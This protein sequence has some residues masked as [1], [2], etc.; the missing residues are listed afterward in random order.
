MPKEDNNVSLSQNSNRANLKK[1]SKKKRKIGFK[2]IIIMFLLLTIGVMAVY[3]NRD[4]IN[5]F[6]AKN[7]K[8][9]PVLNKVFKVPT[10]P[11]LNQSKQ[12]LVETI[13]EKEQ[14]ITDLNNTIDQ[15]KEEKLALERT[16]T[17]LK[18]YEKNYNEFMKQKQAWDENIAKAN[19]DLFIAQYEKMYPENAE[20]IYAQLKSDALTTK[21]HKEYAKT[22]EQM[23]EK[24]AAQSMEILLQTDPEL[25]KIVFNSMS[26]EKRAA[27]LS[28]MKAENSSKVI[29]LIYPE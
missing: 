11:Y 23:D 20:E 17:N 21:K 12:V 29:K 16:I 18:E 27:V 28:A 14:Q 26:S 3:Y 1:S 6:L 4:P 15:L 19:P 7:L 8:Q 9:V 24:V 10:E 13:K 2:G 22:I 25:V 5:N